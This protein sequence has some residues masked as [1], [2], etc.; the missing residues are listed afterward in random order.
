MKRRDLLK[1]GGLSGILTAALFKR[2]PG[3][4]RDSRPMFKVVGVGNAVD[5]MFRESMTGVEFI[6]VKTDAQAPRHSVAPRKL[7]L[8]ET[9]LSADAR[10]EVGRDTAIDVRYWIAEILKD[11]RMLFIVSNRGFFMI[12]F[13][14][15]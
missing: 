12:D 10:P 13:Q 3:A 5:H 7:R 15:T 2:T 8:G 6:A 4:S 14:E 11:A 9:G 1:I